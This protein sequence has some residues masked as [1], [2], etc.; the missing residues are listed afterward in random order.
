MILRTT[1]EKVHAIVGGFHLAPAPDE[2]VA[3]TVAAF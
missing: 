2:I 3:K 1:M